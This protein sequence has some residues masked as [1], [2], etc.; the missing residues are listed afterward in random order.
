MPVELDHLIVRSR[1]KRASAAF[2]AEMLGLPPPTPVGPGGRFHAIRLANGTSLDFADAGHALPN[3]AF[4][5]RVR[6]EGVPSV[7]LTLAASQGQ[8]T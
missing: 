3:G 5:E 1:D 4:R 7:R 8:G 6:E 2:L